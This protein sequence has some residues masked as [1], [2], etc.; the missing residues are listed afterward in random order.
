MSSTTDLSVILDDS[1]PAGINGAEGEV[2]VSTHAKLAYLE[3]VNATARYPGSRIRD[4]WRRSN[5]EPH[6]SARVTPGGL[7][8]VYEEDRRGDVTILTI[9]PRRGRTL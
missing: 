1:D 4:A 8:L 7:R 6:P 5:P 3:R 9:Y 2:K